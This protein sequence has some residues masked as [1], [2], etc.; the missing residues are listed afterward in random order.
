MLNRNLKNLLDRLI[1]NHKMMPELSKVVKIKKLF[2]KKKNSNRSINIIEY[3]LEKKII[4]K[5]FTSKLVI[6][7]LNNRSIKL[8]KNLNKINLDKLL[9]KIKKSKKIYIK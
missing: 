1:P 5:Y 9:I 6:Q 2:T 8:M 3:S 7:A 4:E